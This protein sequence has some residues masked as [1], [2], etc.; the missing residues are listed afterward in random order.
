MALLKG[1]PH[2]S[3]GAKNPTEIE[4]GAYRSAFAVFCL[5]Q[6]ITK[7][8]T[9]VGRLAVHFFLSALVGKVWG[10]LPEG[11]AAGNRGWG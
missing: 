5:T 9:G 3:P 2:H 10:L 1:N 7:R 8:V 4:A 6:L 11:R